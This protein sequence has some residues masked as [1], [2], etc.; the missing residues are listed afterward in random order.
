M[1]LPC[2]RDLLPIICSGRARR[3]GGPSSLTVGAK[4][5]TVPPIRP[6]GPRPGSG[7][8]LKSL[9]DSSKIIMQ[10]GSFF[11]RRRLAECPRIAKFHNTILHPHSQDLAPQYPGTRLFVPLLFT[12]EACAN[13]VVPRLHGLLVHHAG[14][15]R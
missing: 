4:G 11:R 13:L 9:P 15:S 1:T 2:I 8:T 14:P 6:S 7:G 5:D 12:W 3:T 10:G